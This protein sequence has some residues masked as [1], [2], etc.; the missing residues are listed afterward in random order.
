MTEITN[1]SILHIAADATARQVL[2]EYAEM[3][4]WDV[5]STI[6]VAHGME[7]ANRRQFDVII[8]ENG[9]NPNSEAAPSA[10][11]LMRQLR[12]TD[13]ANKQT[14]I[15]L[16]S[17]EPASSQILGDQSAVFDGYL[18]EPFGLAGL[19]EAVLDVMDEL[20]FVRS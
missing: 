10:R 16:T 11:G 19:R 7:I 3:L 15:I 14:P 4:G 9:A 2:G 8:T 17:R 12:A 1:I 18:Q 5:H 6:D 20:V 13:G